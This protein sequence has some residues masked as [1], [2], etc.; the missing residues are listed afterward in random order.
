MFKSTISVFLID[1][2]SEHLIPHVAHRL[3]VANIVLL[4]KWLVAGFLSHTHFRQNLWKI[5]AQ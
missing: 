1:R 4:Q 3:L 5:V 2:L